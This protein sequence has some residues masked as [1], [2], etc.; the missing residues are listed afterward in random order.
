[1][2]DAL[3]EKVQARHQQLVE[4]TTETFDVPG[5]QGILRVRYRV[6]TW[7]EIRRV[8]RNVGQIPDLDDETRE[9]YVA[10]DHLVTA[11]E[12]IYDA[13]LDEDVGEDD[14]PPAGEKWSPALAASLGFEGVRSPRQAVFQIIARDTQVM[15]HYEA[16]MDW[17]D[18]ENA[19]ASEKL[20]GES[21]G[22]SQSS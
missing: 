7:K 14:P 12:A 16:M 18:A 8:G 6:L 13:D 3:R 15:T 1:M 21:G 10:A 2:S 17:Q 9:L 19:Q 11:C 20:V 4:Q 5:Y 22:P